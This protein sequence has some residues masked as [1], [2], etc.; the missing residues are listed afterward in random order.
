ME[1]FVLKKIIHDV[2]Y[3][4]TEVLCGVFIDPA[5]AARSMPQDKG[6]YTITRVTVGVVDDGVVVFDSRPYREPRH[7][8]LVFRGRSTD[9]VIADIYKYGVAAPQEVVVVCANQDRLRQPGDVPVGDAIELL[10]AKH[11]N[12][13][14][15]VIGNGG[16][17]E[18]LGPIIAALANLVNQRWRMVLVYPEGCR[19][20]ECAGSDTT[21]AL[22]DANPHAMPND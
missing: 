2:E 22:G 16:M 6:H 8:V 15:T 14:I 21:W 18:Q 20:V 10:R 11:N 17:S 7:L 5:S 1:M 9:G 3:D 4:D 13:R 19:V 12:T